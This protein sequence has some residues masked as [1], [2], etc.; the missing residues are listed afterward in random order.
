MSNRRDQIQD[1]EI[2]ILRAGSITAE[3]RAAIFEVFDA[4]YRAANHEYLQR[5]IDRIGMLALGTV[6]G[7]GVAYSI[8]HARWMD[9][10]GFE[11]AQL[12]ALHG[13]RCVL[14]AY[15]H[16]GVNG[17]LNEALDAAMQS[18]VETPGHRPERQLSC[19]R[20]GHASRAGAA[21]NPLSVPTA[22]RR[23]TRWQQAVGLAVAEAY[24]S[25][26][27]PET[28]V[29]IGPGTP[30]GYPNEEFEPTEEE[31]AAYAAVDRDRGDNLL[32]INWSPDTPPGW[33]D[34]EPPL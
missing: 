25:T 13:M 12:V 11:D 21:T 1:R 17:R 24:G 4:S 6:G 26:L 5:S 30:I 7:R 23:P 15:R 14:P 20:H 27:D 16:R 19:G 3:Q 8:S 10:P 31:R 29:C 34:L 9:L 32:V 28:F 22:G 18:D 33:D 2:S